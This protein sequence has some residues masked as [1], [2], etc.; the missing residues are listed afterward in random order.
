MAVRLIMS[1]KN[2]RP[3]CQVMGRL[4]FCGLNAIGA[5]RIAKTK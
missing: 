1:I 2:N 4:F 3:T 5:N